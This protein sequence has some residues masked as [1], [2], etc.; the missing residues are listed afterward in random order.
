MP[1]YQSE[2]FYRAKINESMTASATCPIT[3]RLSKLPT[4]TTWLLTISPN[5]EYEEMVEYNGKNDVA[6][7]ITIT[8][9]GINPWSTLL[10]TNGTDYNN[11]LYQ[12]EHTQ[13]DIIR[14]DVNHIH[15][16]QGIGNTTLA[17]NSWVG[18][19]KL[20]VAASDVADPIVV[21]T[22]DPRVTASS[23]TNMGVTKL[24]VA[25][26]DANI[27]IAVGDNDPRLSWKKWFYDIWMTSWATWDGTFRNF[28]YKGVN[29][30]ME[31]TFTWVLLNWLASMSGKLTNRTY[32][33]TITVKPWEV[34]RIYSYIYSSTSVIR[35]TRTWGGQR[36]L[37]GV[38]GSFDLTQSNPRIS[39]IN[40]WVTD[41]TV[42]FQYWTSASDRPI[43]WIGFEVY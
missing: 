17:T 35:I 8:K 10:T 11:T 4:R 13:N 41:M 6:M 38:W 27:P 15:I 29:G 9:R 33:S 39:F 7:T 1:T 25:P 18:I 32:A 21:G 42:D 14:G 19:S 16:N 24:S 36:F 5:T 20:S 31:T 12:R 30:N 2:S 43:F 40:T 22:N 3:I 34:C 23:T 37:E 28:D 26:V